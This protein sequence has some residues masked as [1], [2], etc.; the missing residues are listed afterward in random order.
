MKGILFAS[1]GTTYQE[2]REK[3][4]DA[5]VEAI[6]KDLPGYEIAQAYTSNM[7]RAALKKRDLIVPDAAQALEAM[8][9][10]GVTEVI[11]QPGH[12]LPGIEYDKLCHLAGGCKHRFESMYMGKPLLASDDDIRDMAELLSET[13]PQ[14]DKTAVVFMGHGTTQFANTVYTAL[15]YRFKAIEREDIY[16]GTVESYPDLAV[17]MKM[18]AKR[19][20]RR[21]I[22]APLMQVAGDHALNDMAGHEGDSWASTL[23]AAGYDVE[24]RLI[25]LGE[26][27]SIQKMYIEHIKAALGSEEN[28]GL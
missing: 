23:K 15:D 25:G 16:V 2:A 9:E 27:P 3:H 17:V 26:M 20:Y 12:L 28:H 13:Y 19:D 11:V 5:V 8:A 21:V 6:A 18:M 10:S 1:F 4:I 24:C 22:M 7:I 14:E